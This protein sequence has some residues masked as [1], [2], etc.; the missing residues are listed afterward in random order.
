[1]ADWQYKGG[2]TTPGP[3]DK[4][5][6]VRTPDS[7][8]SEANCTG[9]LTSQSGET[10]R[11]WIHE[12][13]MGFKLGGSFEQSALTRT[14]FARNFAQPSIQIKGQMPNSYQY[15]RLGEFVRESQL[16]A[17]SATSLNA[18]A[19]LIALTI[20]STRRDSKAAVEGPHLKG[21]HTGYHFRGYIL[22]MQRG[23]QKFVNAPGFTF[24]FSPA[25]SYAGIYVTPQ[26]KIVKTLA[27][28]TQVFL[29]HASVPDPDK[30][31]STSPSSVNPVTN[32]VSSLPF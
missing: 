17:L 23:A 24:I 1:M 12:I 6:F 5:Y 29:A 10:L 3:I 9:W 13:Q 4:G 28:W 16:K 8:A 31:T 27:T 7:E 25:Y 20:P 22:S 19:N 18:D 26:A 21:P 15:Q 14:Y 30:V 2:S 32:P 11:L